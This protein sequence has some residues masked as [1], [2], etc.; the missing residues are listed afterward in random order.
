MRGAFDDYRA[1]REDV[2]QDEQDRDTPIR[3]PTLALWG[4][5]FEAGGKM[6]DFRAIWAEMAEHVEFFS[7]PACGHL[8]HEEEPGLVNRELLRFLEPWGRTPAPV[9]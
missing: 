5:E 9:P 8:P 4:E 6:W 1:G 3:C 7:I 2:A